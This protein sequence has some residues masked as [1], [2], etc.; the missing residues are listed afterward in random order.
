MSTIRRQLTRKLLVAFAAPLVFGGAITYALIR[1]EAIEQFD[2]A[3]EAQALAVSTVT[4]VRVDGVV[5]VDASARFMRDFDAPNAGEQGGPA[6]G[7][8]GRGAAGPD[9]DVQGEE[10]DTPA[11][12]QIR[13][14]DGSSIARSASL[15]MAD[16][17][18][19]FGSADEPRLWNLTLPLG[20]AGRAV[21]FRFSPDPIEKRGGGP[22]AEDLVM[23][24][25]V[26]R[27]DLDRAVRSVALLLTGCGAL[28][29]IA[30]FLVVPRV[31]RREFA[32]IEMLADQAGRI[33]ADSL[34]T[35]LA[36]DALP[37]ELA[38]IALRLNDLLARLE[39]SFERERR[40]SADLAHELRTPLAELRSLAELAMK[41]P[42][43]RPADA[44]RDV[45][46]IATQMESIVTRLLA[47]VRSE[48]GELPIANEQTELGA[49][50]RQVWQPFEA[51]ASERALRVTWDVAAEAAVFT[52]PVVLRSILANLL[53]NAVEYTPANGAIAIHAS[54]E[55]SGFEVRVRNDAGGLSA[56]D[57]PRLFDRFWRR[58]AARS[59]TDH[60]GL[61]L[62][63]ARAFARAIGGDLTASMDDAGGLTLTVRIP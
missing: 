16:L 45:L 36:A 6:E 19:E 30:T 11:L 42:E 5:D 9:H 52:D 32:P 62:S 60:V 7:A 29:L 38:P 51:R 56:A 8:A 63:L 43:T 12:F 27:R 25:A 3:L 14:I 59:D 41:W 20:V 1:G 4:R 24:V 37:G 46:A 57:V 2:A 22:P 23:V 61:G 44:D 53:Q 15:G 54:A 58:D 49:L 31:I 50:L 13:R 39:T 35:R 21:G 47:M 28:L 18:F 55:K 10:P 40:F 34:G 48:H 17:P 26:D 33:T